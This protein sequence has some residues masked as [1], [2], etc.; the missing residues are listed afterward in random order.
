[1]PIAINTIPTWWKPNQ[2]VIEALPPAYTIRPLCISDYEGGV[3][4]VEN[5]MN[6]SCLGYLECL[7]QLTL[8]GNVSYEAFEG[9]E[10]FIII[11]QIILIDRLAYMQ[12]NSD[13]YMPIVI[14]DGKKMVAAC[15]TLMVERKFI[16]ECGSLGH[17]E[18]IVVKNDQRGTGLGR[19]IIQQ[20]KHL[21]FKHGCYKITLDCDLKNE[22]FYSKNDFETKGLQM[23]IYYR[24]DP[25]TTPTSPK[26]LNQ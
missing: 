9:G 12:R 13:T 23:C 11:L 10:F 21:A 16:H 2:K 1:M 25:A 24:D 4:M 14:L 15:G 5:L 19:L 3:T 17:I 20:L 22:A 7:G 8:V 18:D 6:N 26:Y